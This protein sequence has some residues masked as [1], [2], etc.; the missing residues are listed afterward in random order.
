LALASG[1]I[2]AGGGFT[3]IGGISRRRIAA[4]DLATGQPTAWN[5]DANSTVYALALSGSTLYAGGA[6][7]SIGGQARNRI[8]ALDAVTTAATAW[9]PG[10]DNFVNALVAA[11]STVYAGGAFANIGG[12]PRRCVAALDTVTT[13]AMTWNPDADNS[14]NTLVLSG[15]TLYAGGYFTNIGGQSRSRLAALDP[16]TSSVL[17]W[18]PNPNYTI[19]AVH[20]TAGGRVYAGGTFTSVGGQS[21]Y[22]FAQFDPPP[23]PGM[24]GASVPSLRYMEGSIWA[25]DVARGGAPTTRSLTLINTGQLPLN[26]TGGA[27]GTPG[28]ALGG[29]CAGDFRIDRVTPS[30]SAP[31]APG[32]TVTV[33]IKFAPTATQRTLGLDAALQVTTDSPLTPSLSI[34]LLGD[35]VPVGV[36][37]LK[38]E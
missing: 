10:A 32:G 38:V 8:A 18:N 23:S 31:L 3:T 36:S 21:R 1:R 33:V 20:A 11:G 27:T 9:N 29:R 12:K 22:C 35:A 34:P 5:P 17:A 16:V 15:S 24:L 4:I 25:V 30:T 26:F 7:T 19:L 6:F 14:I 2:Y 28:L 37:S 13:T